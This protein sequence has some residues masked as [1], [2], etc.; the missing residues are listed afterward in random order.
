MSNHVLIE[1]GQIIT[2]KS[3]EL[4]LESMF[5]MLSIYGMETIKIKPW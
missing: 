1:D 3:K 5:Y 4:Q 2:Y